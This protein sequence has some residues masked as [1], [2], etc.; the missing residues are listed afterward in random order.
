MELEPTTLLATTGARI[1]ALVVSPSPV[2]RNAYGTAL[3]R[4]GYHVVHASTTDDVLWS[5]VAG[6]LGDGVPVHLV[7][8]DARTAG[9]DALLSEV[10]SGSSA[11]AIVVAGQPGARLRD[12]ERVED[13]LNVDQMRAAV[14]RA[15]S[16]AVTRDPESGKYKKPVKA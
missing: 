4:D 5:L 9:I 1:Q 13:A 7:V 11:P 3:S 2:L 8:A 16:T 12:V 14:Q 6:R 10:R 15:L